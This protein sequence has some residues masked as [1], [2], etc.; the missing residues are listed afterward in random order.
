MH[1]VLKIGHQD[2]WQQEICKVTILHPSGWTKV[3]ILIECH[4]FQDHAR[5]FQ[6]WVCY[7]DTRFGHFA[8]VFREIFQMP[9]RVSKHIK[10][11]YWALWQ[12]QL[13]P[14]KQCVPAALHSIQL[15]SRLPWKSAQHKLSLDHCKASNLTLRHRA[16]DG[17]QRL[18]PAESNIVWMQLWIPLKNTRAVRVVSKEARV[19]HRKVQVSS[20]KVKLIPALSIFR[21]ISPLD[22]YFE[23]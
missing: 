20:G 6:F 5:L 17:E 10:D 7:S 22:S 1:T 11:I 18:I 9:L 14:Q 16:N 3:V 2:L 8:L 13:G 19:I 4:H 23:L 21:S 12:I 15:W